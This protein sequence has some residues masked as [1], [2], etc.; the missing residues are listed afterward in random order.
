MR[1]RLFIIIQIILISCSGIFNDAKDVGHDF[2][3]NL[4]ENADT[5]GAELAGGAAQSFRETLTSTKTQLLLDSLINVLGKNLSS[6]AKSSLQMQ[7]YCV[8]F[9][10]TF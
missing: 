10:C 1:Y 3:D 9:Y 2:V 7:R 6:Q 4:E 8:I 5:I